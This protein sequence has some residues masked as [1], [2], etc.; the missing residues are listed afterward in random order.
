MRAPHPTCRR[1][2]RHQGSQ[3]WETGA[4]RLNTI[5]FAKELQKPWSLNFRDSSELTLS[6]SDPNSKCISTMKLQQEGI[7]YKAANA[8]ETAL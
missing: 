6:F 2:Q 4:R 3:K 5:Y 1:C 8:S 7:R